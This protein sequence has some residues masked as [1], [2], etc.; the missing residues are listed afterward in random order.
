MAANL[1]LFLSVYVVLGV[2]GVIGFVRAASRTNRDWDEHPATRRLDRA[3]WRA[4]Q[5]AMRAIRG[6]LGTSATTE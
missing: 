5:E 3:L 4:E 2:A 6:H 1:T